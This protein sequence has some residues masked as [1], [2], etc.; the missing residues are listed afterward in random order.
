MST[1]NRDL[2]LIFAKFPQ[3]GS[4]KTRL[5]KQIGFERAAQMYRAFLTDLALRFSEQDSNLTCDIRWVYVPTESGFP[6]LI[7]RIQRHNIKFERTSFAAYTETGLLQQQL[8]QFTW[9]RQQGYRNV[10]GI[11]TDTPHLPCTYVTGAFDKLVAYDI[12]IGPTYDG[13]YYL[14]GTSS[15]N[16][17][18]RNVEMSTNHVTQ[19]LLKVARDLKLSV[20]L[21]P[22][23]LDVDEKQDLVALLQLVTRASHSPCPFTCKMLR[24]IENIS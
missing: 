10:V 4:V 5:G 21:L 3:A 7:S 22:F 2:L 16:L 24:E 11:S 6:Q 17:I 8:D 12:V 1:A 23:M 20:Y 15:G 19:D 18:Q 9:A 13:G 14:F